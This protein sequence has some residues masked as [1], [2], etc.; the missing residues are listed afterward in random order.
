MPVHLLDRFWKLK[1]FLSTRLSSASVCQCSVCYQALVS[2]DPA[3]HEAH[4]WQHS[5]KYSPSQGP[6]VVPSLG[7]V[8]QA[9]RN[10]L[11]EIW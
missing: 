3:L 6:E 5:K 11:L 9:G 7:G 1:S 2:F 10:E 8:Q 4:I